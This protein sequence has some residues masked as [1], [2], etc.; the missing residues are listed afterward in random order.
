MIKVLPSIGEEN[1]GGELHRWDS[2]I[3]DAASKGSFPTCQSMAWVGIDVDNRIGVNL[4][5]EYYEP[6][7]D[8]MH[9]CKGECSYSL[10]VPPTPLQELFS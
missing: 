8:N 7:E 10:Q 5:G 6:L 3:V 9:V 2:V 4:G 1:G